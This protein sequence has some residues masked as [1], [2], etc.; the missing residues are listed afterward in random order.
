M[1]QWVLESWLPGEVQE[2]W[3]LKSLFGGARG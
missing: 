1:N 3:Q 2:W